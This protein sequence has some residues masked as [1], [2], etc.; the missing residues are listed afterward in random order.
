MRDKQS[1]FL[2]KFTLTLEPVDPLQFSITETRAYFTVKL[3][4]YT[5]LNKSNDTTFIYRYPAVQCKQIKNTIII[6]GISQGAALLEELSYARSE[7]V[8]G[9]NTCTILER[10]AVI[11]NEE[12][13]ISDTTHMYEFLTPWLA[14]N[15]QNA[16]KFYDLKGKPERDAFIQKILIGNL[17]TLAKSLDF[18][19]PLPIIC[20]AKIRFR[21]DWMGRENVMV[22]L[23]KFKTNLRIPDYFGIG[24]SV[25][26]GFGTIKCIP[27]IPGTDDE[28]NA[29]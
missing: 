18:K 17:E 28:V 13:G 10:D 12:F 24:Q 22:F 29:G 21:I 4:E 27:E 2:K 15:Q 19:T 23:G 7:M 9:K 5:V 25:L 26:Q 1:M 14:L 11:Q 8:S 3:E 16:K 20:K 6:I